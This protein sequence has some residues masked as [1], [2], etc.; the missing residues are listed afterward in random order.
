MGRI[1]RYNGIEPEI[2]SGVFLAE[3]SFVIGDVKI[4]KNSS[5]WFNTVIRGDLNSI[6]IGENVSIQDLVLIHVSRKGP[7]AIIGDNVTIGHK[8]TVHGAKIS[9]NVLVGMGAI[10]LDGCEI[11]E[12][13]VIG[14][15]AVVTEGMKVPPYTLVVGIPAK[16]KKTFER[17]EVERFSNF[18]KEYLLLKEE[19][20]RMEGK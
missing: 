7:P 9:N 13:S 20:L 5:I 6:R 16:P 12:Y 4:G 10:L 19:Y 17:S 2:G 18:Y 1:I 15:G 11:G 8:A 3:G 14:A